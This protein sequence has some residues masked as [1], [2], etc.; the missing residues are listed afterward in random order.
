MRV[1]HIAA[2]FAFAGALGLLAVPADAA[3]KRPRVTAG[4]G[5]TVVVTRDENGRTRTR[6]IIQKRS[7]LDPGTETIPGERSDHEYA[8]LPG[9]RGIDV[10][11]N[12]PFGANQ[13]ALPGPFT[14]PSKN[15]PWLTGN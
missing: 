2:A 8:F 1:T 11:D 13:T 5:H 12:T 10:Q 9:Q 7:Y 6:I 15:N 3:P 4:A 14:L